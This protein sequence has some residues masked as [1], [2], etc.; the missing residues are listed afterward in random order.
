MKHVDEYRAPERV[1]RLAAAIAE[2]VKRPM[3]V[4][5]VCGGQTHSI[6]R[7]GIDQLLPPALTLIHGPGCP[8]CVTP[9]AVIDAAIGL[10]HRPGV[11]LCS[12]GDMLRVPGSRTSLIAARAAGAAV[13][14]VHSPLEAFALARADPAREVVFFAVGFETTAP[15]TAMLLVEA[16]RLGVSNVSVL[17]AHVRVPAA[18]E[19]LLADPATKLDGFLAAGHVCAVMGTAEYEPIARRHHVPIV[20]TGFEPVDILQGL[21]MCV[22]DIAARR[23]RVRNAYARVVRPEGSRAARAALARCFTA[24]DSDWRGLGRIE[25]GGF[26]IAPAFAAFDA[27]QRYDI[28][29]AAGGEDPRCRAGDVLRGA[30]RP[31]RC[32]SF[33]TACTP[34]HPLG[35]PMVSGE[36]ACAAYHRYRSIAP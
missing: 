17:C 10:A 12:F 7:F 9:I 8:V 32:P 22:E 15:A 25:A 4:M 1:R 5:E 19:A 14:I 34:E 16:Q 30:L 20:I 11:T 27:A 29:R 36:G 23:A 18:L 24:V 26:A 13:R 3:R 21:L 31:D 6:V 35:A 33:G 28:G 2:D